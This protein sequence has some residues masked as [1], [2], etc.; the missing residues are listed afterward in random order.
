MTNLK[1]VSTPFASH[2]KLSD[3]RSP[4]TMEEQR[5]MDSFPDVNHI[6]FVIYDMTCILCYEY[7]KH[8]YV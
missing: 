8:V 6:G 7:C 5:Y 1:P 2:Y 3:V 4:K